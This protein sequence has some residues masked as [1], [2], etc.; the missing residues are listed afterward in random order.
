M[1]A[2][3]VVRMRAKPGFEQQVIETAKAHKRSHIQGMRSMI[4]IKTGERSYCSIGE[5]DSME[6]LVAARPLMIKN[7]DIVRD[8]LE[9]LG[10]GMGITDA[11]SGE[12]CAELFR[13]A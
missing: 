2:F 12:V 11:V 4:I 13:R 7:L 3:N 9:D 1:T 6:H 10:D 5:W 8:M